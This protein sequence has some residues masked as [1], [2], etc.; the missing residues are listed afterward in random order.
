[1]KDTK[2]L[3]SKAATLTYFD[4]KK[5]TVVSADASSFGLGGV[6]LQAD[7]DVLKPV[8][9]CSR[10]LT[11]AEQR[12]AQIEKE[13]LASVWACEKFYQYLTGLPDFQLLTDHKPLVPLMSTK[14]IDA[15]PIRCQRLLLRMMRFNPSVKYVPGKELV[16]ADALS[17]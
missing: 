3:V 10:T 14:S 13:C 2:Q 5:P 8:A 11:Q 4:P 12:Y 16:I 9:F 7:N 6:L 15:V 17:R 1:V